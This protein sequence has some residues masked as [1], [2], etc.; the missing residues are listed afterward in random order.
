MQPEAAGIA[1]CCRLV[2][3][4]VRGFKSLRDLTIELGESRVAILAGPNGSGKTAV[5]ESLLLLRDIL[6][7]LE[8]RTVN[9][10]QR[11]WGYRNVAWMH[12]EEEPIHLEVAIDCSGCSADDLEPVLAGIGAEC[13]S[14][15]CPPKGRLSYSVTVTGAGGAFEIV[16]ERIE[17]ED[18]GAVSI[19]GGAGLRLGGATVGL[20]ELRGILGLYVDQKLVRQRVDWETLVDRASRAAGAPREAVEALLASI[21]VVGSFIDSITVLRPLDYVSMRSPQALGAPSRLAEDGS[22]LVPLLFRIGRGRLPEDI[23][24]VLAQV[25]GARDVTGYFEPT[26]DGRIILRLVVDGVELAPPSIPEGAWKTM[27]LMAA[28]LMGS[29]VIAVDEFENS[30]HPFA[31]ELLLEE[32]RRSG[33]TVIVATHSPTVIDAARSLEEI[34]VLELSGGETRASRVRE[35]EKLAEKLR[36]LGLTPSEALLYRIGV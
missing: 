13:S 34:I 4:R 2:R 9:P 3:L 8:G 29:S 30:L 20:R 12:R 6:D 5:I 36:E 27:A 31:Q 28:V 21:I 24:V 1:R 19:G 23:G 22:N 32:L 14:T 26:P 15:A 10:F 18:V 7:Y 17:L 25:L 35:P 11:W 16:S 33:A